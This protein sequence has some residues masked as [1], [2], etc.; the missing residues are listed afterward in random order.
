MDMG[1]SGDGS[2][3]W[4]S[5]LS[6]RTADTSGSDGYLVSGLKGEPKTNT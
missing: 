3:P 2:L 6:T 4:S 1:V 5:F